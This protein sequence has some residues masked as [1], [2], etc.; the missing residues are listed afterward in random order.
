[1]RKQFKNTVLKLASKD[2]KIVLVFG[3]ISVYLFNDFQKKYPKRFYNMGICESTLVSVS[4]GLRHGGLIPFVHSIAPFVTER[5]AEQIKVDLVYND[6]PANIVTCGSTF[7]YAWDGPTHH[8]WFDIEIFRTLPNTEIFQP[9]SDKEVDALMSKF[10]KSNNTSYFRLSDNPHGYSL[11]LKPGKGTE[12][13]NKNSKTTV[14]TCGPILKNVLPA[15]KDLDVNLIYFNT[16]K[17]LDVSLI[18][19]FIKTKFKII[20]DSFGFL[21][22]IT[23]KIKCNYDYLGLPEKFCVSYGKID[24]VRKN[25]GL[26]IKSIR[27]FIQKR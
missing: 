10:Y 22:S 20:H 3:D 7:D 16:I 9:G 4:A 5:A 25:A 15:C 26:D 21:E 24:D 19:K 8:A 18:K 2:D 1:M 13:F 27:R 12:V 17:P 23:S 11:E 14:I 6:L